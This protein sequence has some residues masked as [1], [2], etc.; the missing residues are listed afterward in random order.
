MT[1]DTTVGY[2]YIGT[3]QHEPHSTATRELIN[4]A[5]GERIVDHR[6][7]RRI[8]VD[9]AVQAA[10]SAQDVWAGWNPAAR[11]DVLL[12]WADL[13]H[14]HRS[15]LGE[16]DTTNMGRV[17]KEAVDDAVAAPRM[18]RY[19]AGQVDRMLGDQ[20]PAVPGYLSYTVLEPL[21]VIGVIL[22]WN[23]PLGVS[24]V[25]SR[26][27]WP[28]A[29]RQWSN[30]ANGRPSRRCDWR[31]SSPKPAHPMVWSTSFPAP[32]SPARL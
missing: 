7:E 10:S 29:T 15:E 23:G 17:L 16:L 32:A 28:A 3:S 30:Q 8:D 9:R 14:A 12:R 24:A 11:V 2:P 18:I 27:R 19:W 20:I 22:P 21:G 5:N 4:P 13:V 26:L 25:A 1:L 6:R 31:R